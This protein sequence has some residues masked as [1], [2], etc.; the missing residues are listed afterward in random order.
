M[1]PI[2]FALTPLRPLGLS[3]THTRRYQYRSLVMHASNLRPVFAL[4]LLSL[5]ACGDEAPATTD[6]DVRG[7]R[8]DTGS[9][10]GTDGSGDDEDTSRPDVGGDDTGG[11]DTGAPDTVEPDG[12]TSAVCGNNIREPG[13][14]CDGTDVPPQANC[15]TQGFLAG[16]LQCAGT[17]SGFNIP[18]G[19]YNELCGDGL[20][21]GI[22]ECEGSDLRGSS[23]ESLGFA[24]GGEGE[25]VCTGGCLIDTGACEESICGNGHREVGF[26]ACD[27]TDFGDDSCRE[28][29]FWGGDLS[30]TDDC[31]TASA[32]DCVP[33]I[34]ENGT[35]E[36]DEVCDIGGAFAQS[37]SDFTYEVEVPVE[38]SGEGSGATEIVEMNYAGGVINCTDACM[39][40]SLAG[41]LT[42]EQLDAATD[43]DEDGVPDGDDNCPD[44]ANPRQLDFDLDDTG[45]VCDAPVVYDVLVEGDDTSLVA[46]TLGVAG[47]LGGA[48][49]EFPIELTVEEVEYTVTFDDDGGYSASISIIFAEQDVHV[50]IEGTETIPGFPATP[51]EF[52]LNIADALLIS[53]DVDGLVVPES[54]IEQYLAGEFDGDSPDFDALFLATLTALDTPVAVGD[55]A[56]T[57]TG[58]SAVLSRYFDT[59]TINLADDLVVLGEF[60][61]SLPLIPG[62]PFGLPTDCGL[63]GLYGSVAAGRAE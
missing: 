51:T 21:T 1:S 5:A 38:G 29:G 7:G 25:A 9:D 35:I 28:R 30:C 39:D 59:L 49:A 37:C 27:D 57:L 8:G 50:F 47:G 13:E 11:D 34:C 4:L 54:T 46:T 26:E 19:C 2:A 10:A 22:E 14:L 44:D 63:Y 41:C 15:E 18:G 53:A 3:A 36:G 23:C 58:T 24:P 56:S 20:A 61:V 55:A 45:N 17:C 32:D 62:I 52:D 6:D 48:P 60:Q 42:A 40:F 12:T 33:N 43:S 16:T 31:T